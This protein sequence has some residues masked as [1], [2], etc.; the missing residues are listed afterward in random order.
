MTAPGSAA[1]EAA[2]LFAAGQ[3]WLRARS[4]GLSEDLRHGEHVATGSAEC[5]V[6]PLCQ[7]ISAV[8]QVKPE[9]VEHLLD[10]AASVV[11]ALRSAIGPEAART[12]D[13]RGGVQHIDV[14][15]G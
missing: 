11:A 4:S 10:A 15:E 2:A 6:C 9:T 7:A 1:E 8:R 12:P 5:T 3:E 13:G 14:R